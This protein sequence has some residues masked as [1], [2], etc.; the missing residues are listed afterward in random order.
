MDSRFLVAVM[1]ALTS[2]CGLNPIAPSGTATS[3]KAP[4]VSAT[5]ARSATPSPSPS[6]SPTATSTP[7]GGG[8]GVILYWDE[9]SQEDS[10]RLGDLGGRESTLLIS[11][12]DLAG[13][14]PNLGNSDPLVTPSADPNYILISYCTLGITVMYCQNAHAV[15]VL[16]PLGVREIAV[17]EGDYRVKWSPDGMMLAA[18]GPRSGATTNLYIFDREGDMLLRHRIVGWSSD[19]YW[20]PD[21]SQLIW[22]Q[23]GI[24]HAMNTDGSSERELAGAYFGDAMYEGVLDP[25]SPECITYSPSG[26]SVAYSDRFGLFVFTAGPDFSDPR[27][28]VV[29]TDPAN[30]SDTTYWDC[31]SE[32]SPDGD[33][34]LLKFDTTCQGGDCTFSPSDPRWLLIE[35]VSGREVNLDEY[36]GSARRPQVCGFT[37]GSSL[38][39][40]DQGVLTVVSLSSS[41]SYVI[42]GLHVCPFAWYGQNESL[43]PSPY[44]EPRQPFA[45]PS[46]TVAPWTPATP[47]LYDDFEADEPFSPKWFVSPDPAVK[48]VREEGRLRLTRL[49]SN[50]EARIEF[51]LAEPRYGEAYPRSIYEIGRFEAELTL[52]SVDFT[53]GKGDTRGQDGGFAVIAILL[54]A[55]TEWATECWLWVFSASSPPEFVCRVREGERSLYST[56]SREIEFGR[57]YVVGIE[58]NPASAAIRYYFEGEEIGAYQ[59]SRS[60]DLVNASVSPVIALWGQAGIAIEADVDNVYIGR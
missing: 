20:T 32:W 36:R 55:D 28:L 27:P 46:P 30:T 35:T 49:P 47:A 37:P 16:D 52:N 9:F 19:P 59:S 17:P 34:L 44:S 6:P 42:P 1:F 22:N 11:Q 48:Y 25:P 50:A 8:A 14:L 12:A 54:T 56:I 2:S 21:S 38:V 58:V 57:P 4:S 33:Y 29:P 15:V 5:I 45:I 51:Q 24:L 3:A 10:L 13:I 7:P 23:N 40:L 60:G 43:P 18:Y 53:G 31:S 39:L 26:D 41:L